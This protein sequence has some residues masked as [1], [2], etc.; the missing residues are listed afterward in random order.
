M[1]LP[2]GFTE[3]QGKKR[4]EIARALLRDK[5]FAG[6]GTMDRMQRAYAIATA[7]VGEM[8]RHSPGDKTAYKSYLITEGFDGLFHVSKGGR[9]VNLRLSEVRAHIAT[10]RSMNEA[11]EA[12][13]ELGNNPVSVGARWGAAP[14]SAYKADPDREEIWFHVHGTADGKVAA[15]A[16]RDFLEEKWPAT[17]GARDYVEEREPHE[18]RV[19]FEITVGGP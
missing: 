11:K 4:D 8:S 6:R 14:N 10:A 19:D 15:N 16:V 17:G 7:Q 12:I 5:H 3:E 9:R 13:D 2:S 1:P 18:G